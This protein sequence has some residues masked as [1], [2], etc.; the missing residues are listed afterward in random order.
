MRRRGAGFSV[1]GRQEASAL[2]AVW[3]TANGHLPTHLARLWQ[4]GSLTFI[5]NLVIEVSVSLLNI[6]T[7]S[8]NLQAKIYLRTATP[9]DEVTFETF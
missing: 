2:P 5:T 9:A 7:I 6:V 8:R 4:R 1:S 3:L